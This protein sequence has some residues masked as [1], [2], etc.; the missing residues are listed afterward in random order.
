[1][2]YCYTHGGDRDTF[3]ETYGREP[4]DFSANS[5]PL[6]VPEAVQRAVCASA[7]RCDSYPDPYCRALRNA[8]SDVHALPPAHILC[9]NGS[10][11]LLYRLALAKKPKQALVL[12]PTFSEYEQALRLVG[13]R[14]EHW[15]LS[16]SDGFALD[17]RLCEKITAQTDLVVVCQP[18]NPTGLVAER[19]VMEHIL[20]RC[21]QTD[22]MLVVDECFLDFLEDEASY[23]LRGRVEDSGHL[24]LL[25]A[26][27]KLYGMAGLRLGYCLCR[28]EELLGAMQASG[29][30]WAVS[31]PAQAA[32]LAAL[33]CTEYVDAVR[34]LVHTER[35]WLKQELETLG[36]FVLDGRAN[37]LLFR[38]P[39]ALGGRLEAQGILL[40]DCSNF[41]GLSKGWYRTAVRTHA[42]NRTLIHAMKGAMA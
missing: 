9:G 10:A 1:M 15:M 29:Q 38:A 13:C 11:D 26:F 5:S 14:V 27:T 19:T 36:F 25:K 35:A 34:R 18:N 7:A 40:R 20:R 16:E 2:N 33:S 24:L 28:D 31:T 12:A 17:V 37:Y 8:L 39:E 30:P 21:E 23:T 3:V 6:G 41:Y 42:D 22:T 32:G 4:L